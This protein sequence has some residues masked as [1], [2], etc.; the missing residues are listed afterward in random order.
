MNQP[1]GSHWRLELAIV[2]LNARKSFLISF[3][4]IAD[5]L[6][7]CRKCFQSSR[8]A[9]PSRSLEPSPGKYPDTTLQSSSMVGSTGILAGLNGLGS[10]HSSA[11][12]VF[13]RNQNK[14][15]EVGAWRRSHGND[16]ARW[17]LCGL[18]MFVCLL[19]SI[20]WRRKVIFRSIVSLVGMVFYN[21]VFWCAAICELSSKIFR[22]P[23][24]K[25]NSKIPVL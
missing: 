12:E 1:R 25:Q 19:D 2:L 22:L 18:T 11:A 23:G 14:L 15:L 16:V 3:L 10:P 17:S 13:G 24:L 8:K 21:F 4:S 9:S 20:A 5:F 6:H 7:L